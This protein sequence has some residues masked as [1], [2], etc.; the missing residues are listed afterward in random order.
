MIRADR[1]AASMPSVIF[2]RVLAALS[3]LFFCSGVSALIYQVLWIRLLGLTFGVTIYAAATVSASFMAGRALGSA[4]APGL[5]ARG[6]RPLVWVGAGR[7]GPRG[8]QGGA[9]RRQRRRGGAGRRGAPAAG[10]VRRARAPD[11]PPRHGEPCRTRHTPTFVRSALSVAPVVA[12]AG[13]R[14][15]LRNGVRG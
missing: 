5:A 13:C 4:R 14:G 9:R 3:I 2:S 1:L 12:V 8:L 6:R 11:W 15:A 7:H 10:V